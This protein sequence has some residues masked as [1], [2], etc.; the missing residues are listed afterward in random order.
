MPFV[1]L[2]PTYY[3]QEEKEPLE[4][5]LLLYKEANETFDGSIMIKHL[6][7]DVT[8]GSQDAGA[9]IEGLEDVARYIV[10]RFH[11]FGQYRET[12]PRVLS[13]GYAPH[14]KPC[15]VINLDG[16]NDCYVAIE[17]NE[18]HKITKIFTT[19]IKPLVDEVKIVDKF[20]S[21]IHD[22]DAHLREAYLYGYLQ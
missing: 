7:H 8:Y 16:V 10:E 18:L 2:W 5:L 17:V 21:E 15:L 1:S 9:D 19:T 11:F 14:N 12:K 3:K 22:E 20:D 13:K 6:A 4:K